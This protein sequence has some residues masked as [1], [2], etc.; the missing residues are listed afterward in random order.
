MHTL[1]YDALVA[2]AAL[3]HQTAADTR[4]RDRSRR[5]L[6]AVAVALLR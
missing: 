5:R 2:S 6:R 3:A 4:T 1:T